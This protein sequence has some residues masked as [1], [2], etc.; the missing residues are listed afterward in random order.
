VPVP[1]SERLQK[2]P[3]E[4]TFQ[5]VTFPRLIEAPLSGWNDHPTLFCSQS[6][7]TDHCRCKPS[8][9]FGFQF[10]VSRQILCALYLRS[11]HPI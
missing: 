9:K 5:M 7:R 10:R 6:R 1:N 11:C 2:T 3:R 4:R 8:E